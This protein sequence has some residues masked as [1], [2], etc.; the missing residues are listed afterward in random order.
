MELSESS[1][2]PSWEIY[3]VVCDIRNMLRHIGSKVLFVKRLFNRAAHCIAALAR[4]GSWPQIG[5]PC[6]QWKLAPFCY[7]ILGPCSMFILLCVAGFFFQ[8]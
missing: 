2:D 4:R 7:V 1:S 3:S 6:R 5:C 8:L